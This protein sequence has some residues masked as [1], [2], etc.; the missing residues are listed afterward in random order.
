MNRRRFEDLSLLKQ[1]TR[2]GIFGSFSEGHKEDLLAL[3]EYLHDE[4]GY[5]ARISEDLTHLLSR[6]YS[7]TSSRDY[8]LSELLIEK[9]D[10][11]VLVFPFPTDSDSHHF[12]QS[13]SIEY[14]L[15]KERRKP[16]VVLLCEEGLRD[17]IPHSFGGVM[18]GS[19][20]IDTPGFECD[21]IDYNSLE[22]IFP[23]LTMICYRFVRKIWY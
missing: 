8:A 3:R 9:S 2:I 7:D 17:S 18:K 22:D 4:L 13:V 15:I 12:T 11:H 16:C 21:V 6:S 23:Q 14:A 19:L 20:T 1:K 5:C 10:I